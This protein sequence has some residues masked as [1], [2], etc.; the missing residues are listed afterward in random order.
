MSL[1]N[2]LNAIPCGE[3]HIVDLPIEVRQY[4]SNKVTKQNKELFRPLV[5]EACAKHYVEKTLKPVNNGLNFLTGDITQED[6]YIVLPYLLDN[7]WIE[8]TTG[9]GGIYPGARG[10]NVQPF[11]EGSYDYAIIVRAI[12]KGHK[13]TLEPLRVLTIAQLRAQTK[14]SNFK[15][16]YLSNPTRQL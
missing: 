8:I 5:C 1:M 14:I 15:G 2:R 9:P 3:M 7:K 10:V 12:K 13:V 11:L 4:I 6:S 16:Y